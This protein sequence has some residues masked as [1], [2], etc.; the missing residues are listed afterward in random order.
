MFAQ[1]VI[2]CCA[3]LTA[4]NSQLTPLG[5]CAQEEHTRNIH[6]CKRWHDP[7]CLPVLDCLWASLIGSGNS[8]CAISI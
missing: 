7:Q 3:S 5:E 4:S 1:F 8:Y 6:L 2:S